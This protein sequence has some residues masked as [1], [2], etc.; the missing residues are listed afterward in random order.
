ME[1]ANPR[2]S[3]AN[4][5]QLTANPRQSTAIPRE[6]TANSSLLSEKLY[7][8]APLLPAVAQQHS[9]TLGNPQSPPPLLPHPQYGVEGGSA[10]PAWCQSPHFS[11]S[12][13]P[14]HAAPS[15]TS[16][17]RGDTQSRVEERA[18]PIRPPA[19]STADFTSLYERCVAGGLKACM[20]LSYISGRQLV[21]LSCSLPTYSKMPIVPAEG[22]SRHRRWRRCGP[23]ANT[24]VDK[25]N[26]PAGGNEPPPPP[27]RLTSL[28]PVPPPPTPTPATPPSPPAKRKRK[29]RNELELLR[30]WGRRTNFFS[31]PCPARLRHPRLCRP[32][33]L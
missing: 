2:Q 29:R 9:S 6:S 28:P 10:G 20:I 30:E 15:W 14:S 22:R 1:T 18:S 17:V 23:N 31:R 21:N 8:A 32:H 24:A 7:P 4:P 19:V 5:R 27:P 12:S 16:V 33:P 11:P 26:A 25:D 13:P 3:T